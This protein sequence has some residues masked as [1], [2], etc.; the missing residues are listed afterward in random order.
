M[1]MAVAPDLP[2]LQPQQAAVTCLRCSGYGVVFVCEEPECKEKAICVCGEGD[3]Y[4]PCCGGKGV[5]CNDS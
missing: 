2:S 1:S 4:C 5:L 3:A